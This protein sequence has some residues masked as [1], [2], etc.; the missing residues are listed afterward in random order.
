MSQPLIKHITTNFLNFGTKSC[1][2]RYLFWLV[3][4]NVSKIFF[5]LIKTNN[6]IGEIWR[7]KFKKFVVMCLI[8]F[9]ES[10]AMYVNNSIYEMEY[11]C[12]QT[13]Q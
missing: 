7:Q 9:W 11:F 1:Q 12:G 13:A 10:L 2:S 6:G 5:K 3:S 4:K 8:K